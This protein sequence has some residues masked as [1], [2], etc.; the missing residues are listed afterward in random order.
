[1]IPPANCAEF[2]GKDDDEQLQWE[3]TPPSSVPPT[4]VK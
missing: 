4:Q 1:M 2:I 3:F